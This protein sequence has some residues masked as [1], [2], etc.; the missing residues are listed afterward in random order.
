MYETRRSELTNN[1]ITRSIYQLGILQVNKANSGWYPYWMTSHMMLHH[2]HLPV[3]R[4][5]WGL[6]KRSLQEISIIN[7]TRRQ[8]RSQLH[9]I[10]KLNQ[11]NVAL[12]LIGK[13]RVSE[14]LSDIVLFLRV[15]CL[16][17]AT[18]A[19]LRHS[20]DQLPESCSLSGTCSHLLLPSR[21]RPVVSPDFVDHFLSAH[22]QPRIPPA[23]WT[24]AM[25]LMPPT[26][27]TQSMKIRAH[28]HL[29]IYPHPLHFYECS[30]TLHLS[31]WIESEQWLTQ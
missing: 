2:P 26:P 19:H 8:T 24:L 25:V 1:V 27:T 17:Y 13:H 14:V 12:S 22:I 6:S 29:P 10:T 4:V 9:Q 30:P 15:L 18:V 31:L 7:D 28:F 3:V 5:A 20:M 11:N 21:D 23:A 16:W